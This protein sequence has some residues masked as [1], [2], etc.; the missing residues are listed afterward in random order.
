MP[1]RDA[2]SPMLLVPTKKMLTPPENG[3]LSLTLIFCIFN[4]RTWHLSYTGQHHEKG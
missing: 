4:I 1:H 2:T 3:E